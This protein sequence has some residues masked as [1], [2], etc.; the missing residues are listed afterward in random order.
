MSKKQTYPIRIDEQM[1]DLPAE[2]PKLVYLT[3]K[4]GAFANPLASDFDAWAAIG[5]YK[6]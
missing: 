6:V 1:T 2:A 5:W 4:A 3:N